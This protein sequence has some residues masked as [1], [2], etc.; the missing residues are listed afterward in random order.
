MMLKAEWAVDLQGLKLRPIQLHLR[1]NLFPLRLKYL[2]RS[3]KVQL[4]A[5]LEF[6]NQYNYIIMMLLRENIIGIMRGF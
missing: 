6:I 4:K 2:E 3:A 1:L 5:S